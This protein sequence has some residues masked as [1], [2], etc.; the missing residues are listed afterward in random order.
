MLDNVWLPEGKALSVLASP[1]LAWAEGWLALRRTL[2]ALLAYVQAQVQHA[3]AD[4]MPYRRFVPGQGD[5][6]S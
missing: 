5:R 3:A 2:V 4:L 6:A 1:V